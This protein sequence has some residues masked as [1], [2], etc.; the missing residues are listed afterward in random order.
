MDGMA[1]APAPNHSRF[2]Q[3]MQGKIIVRDRSNRPIWLRCAVGVLVV[4]IA[5]AI[6]LQF[7]G[8][9]ERRATFLTFYPAV[10][11]AALY[12]GFRAGLLATVVSAALADYFWIDPVGQ[13]SITNSADLIS[14]VVFLVSGTLIS[15]LAG[16]T[17]RAQARA[18]KAETQLKINAEREKTIGALQESEE[19]YRVTLSSIGDAVI[20]TDTKA[21]ITFF[22]P[23]ASALTGW[24]L[25]EVLGQ[26]VQSVFRIINEQT[27]EQAE[28]IVERVLREGCTVA[29]ANHTALVTS[30]GREI[31]IEDSAAPIRDNEGKVA[32]IIL[33]FHDVAERRLAQ[34]ALKE[35]EEHYRSLF[36][37]MLNGYAYC[38][39]LFENDQPEDFIY[40]S[41]NSAFENLTGL[42][43]VIGKNVSE[44]IPGIRESDSNL[45]EI[46]GR[47]ARTGV[48]ER[49]E[50]YVEALRMW[51][52]ISVYSPRKEHFVAVFDV[53]TERKRAEEELLRAKEEWERTFDSVPDLIAI[54]DTR[55][56]IVRTNLAMAQ[57]LGV[58][59]EQC[60]GLHCCESVHGSLVP[61][62]FCPHTLTL[63]DG[64]EHVAEVHEERLGGDFLVSTTPFRDEKGVMIGTVHVARDITER[65]QMEEELRKSRDDLEL[66]VHERTVDLKTYMAKLEQSNQS[67]QDFASIAAHDMKEPLRKVI[68]FGNMLRQKSGDSMGQ[69]GND[70]LNR[71]LHATE[72]MQSL[73]TGL[74]DYSRVATTSEPFKE[75]DLSDLIVEVLSDLEVRIVKTGG[76][77][78]VEILPVISADPTQMRQLFQNL[79]GNALKFHKADEKP[80]IRVKKAATC[81]GRV[82]IIVEDNG[83]GFEEQYLEKIFAPFQR[84]HGRSEYEGTGMGL[85]ICKKIVERHGGSIMA[86]SEPWKGS[87]FIVT[88]PLNRLQGKN[89]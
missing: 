44:V 69:A 39:M 57:R 50:T 60:V 29:L 37:N 54:M 74:L 47:V 40:L 53:I 13:F 49:F 58:T 70:Y 31:P 71:M 19:R 83:I 25:E 1:N 21:K 89:L 41:V 10:A 68:S 55:H 32:G 73:L 66:R 51:F 20:A 30:D 6:R 76:K 22:N 62:E 56:R 45:F 63:K 67:L 42:K 61:P 36:D 78:Q 8:I 72:R 75:V 52:S 84:L 7:L 81:N 85:A 43:N 38:K 64:H 80:V 34:E 35:S 2:W 65:K 87:T 48:P 15:Y 5:A 77:V 17:Y 3:Y 12:G 59:P 46:Y 11:V 88:F 27:H 82:Q 86:K 18:H 14:M 9:L 16:A 79:I 28:D 24:K 4:I 23:V 33:V 26:P